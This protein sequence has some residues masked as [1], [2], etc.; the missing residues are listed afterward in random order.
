MEVK[1]LHRQFADS[2]EDEAYLDGISRRIKRLP[3]ALFP[4]TGSGVTGATTASN[5]AAEDAHLP[6]K[7]WPSDATVETTPPQT[8]DEIVKGGL[9]EE[10]KMLLLNTLMATDHRKL[11][12]S[13]TSADSVVEMAER[14]DASETIQTPLREDDDDQSSWLSLDSEGLS[15]NSSD[16]PDHEFRRDGSHE[17]Y[18]TYISG[19]RSLAE[20]EAEQ[21]N[22]KGG[23][24]QTASWNSNQVVQ[25]DRPASKSY[26]RDGCS[27]NVCES[28]QRRASVSSLRRETELPIDDRPIPGTARRNLMPTLLRKKTM[29]GTGGVTGPNDTSHRSS[30][31]ASAKVGGGGSSSN[32]R[33]DAPAFYRRSSDYGGVRPMTSDSDPIRRRASLGS[34]VQRGSR[35]GPSNSRR[36]SK[37]ALERRKST[38]DVP[39]GSRTGP[40]AYCRRSTYGHERDTASRS[41]LERRASASTTRGGKT[42]P[43]KGA[44]QPPR[45]PSVGRMGSILG[46]LFQKMSS[47]AKSTESHSLSPE[48]LARLDRPLSGMHAGHHKTSTDSKSGRKTYG[49]CYTRRLSL[50]SHASSRASNREML[51]FDDDMS[52][53]C[54]G[55]E[56]SVESK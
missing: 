4:T 54:S 53:C 33:R 43:D 5:D 38:A 19:M 14:V 8:P 48:E 16:H 47:L 39:S 55:S 34:P 21:S 12:R 17:S 41:S 49:E 32:R 31:G 13:T 36:Q 3:L 22:M 37:S 1:D 10:S 46:G 11:G 24:E 20:H 7:T 18:G 25:R 27:K 52:S 35:D 29:H 40:S 44:G 15:Q 45:R 26:D 2:A 9:P 51:E 56:F 30:T 42:E 6:Q 28:A 50:V 23:S